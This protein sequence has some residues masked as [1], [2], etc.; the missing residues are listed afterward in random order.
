[1]LHALTRSLWAALALL[2]CFALTGCEKPKPPTLEPESAVVKSVTPAGL[3]LELTVDAY[4]PNSIPLIARKLKARV[5]IDGKV[6]LGEVEVPT[7]VNIKAKSH[8]KIVAPVSLAWGDAASIAMM[9]LSKETV[10]FTVEGTASVGT[11]DI[12]FDIP[13]ETSGSLTRKQ[14]MELGAKNLPQLPQLP[15]LPF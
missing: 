9:A 12:N 13:F 7:K 8:E 10:P 1:M 11:D 14:L 2:V 3:E 4:N 15:P 6:D 5:K